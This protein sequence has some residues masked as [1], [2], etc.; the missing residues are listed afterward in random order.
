MDEAVDAAACAAD[1]VPVA[2][3]LTGGGTVVIG[4]GCL[5][6]SLVLSLD[7][8]PALREVGRSYQVLLAALA[9]ALA[10]PGLVRQGLSDL[11]LGDLKVSGNAQRRSRRALLH[12]GTLLGALDRPLMTRY[13]R[14]PSRQPAYRARRP[15]GAFVTN[16]SLPTR[17]LRVRLRAL[18]VMLNS[19]DEFS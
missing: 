7:Q 16:L 5:N 2:R 15:H 4:P 17:E 12:Q 6:F 8:R 18:A 13:L 14:E 11:A 9:T 3:R 1:H 19:A 10:I